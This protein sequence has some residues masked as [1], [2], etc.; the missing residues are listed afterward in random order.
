MRVWTWLIML[1]FLVATSLS[2]FAVTVTA[3]RGSVMVRTH[4]GFV[5]V[6]GGASVGAGGQVAV[7]PGGKARVVYGSGCTVLLGPGRVWS[8]PEKAPCANQRKVVDL[9]G[10]RRMANG[11]GPTNTYSD[12]DITPYL[13]LIVGAA[14]VGI[15]FAVNK[16]SRSNNPA[17]P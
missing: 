7:A 13:P 3:E 10:A 9:T 12:P 14:G 6:A 1:P 16:S 17:S 8:I 5:P 15:Y 4:D 11:Q 2:A